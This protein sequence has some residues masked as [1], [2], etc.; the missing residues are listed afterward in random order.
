MAK[1][2]SSSLLRNKE[3]KIDRLLSFM[4]PG[5]GEGVFPSTRSAF[6]SLSL[7]PATCNKTER[8][9]SPPGAQEVGTQKNVQRE[10]WGWA[11]RAGRGV[12]ERHVYKKKRGAGGV[13]GPGSVQ[14]NGS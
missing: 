6:S 2:R 7:C 1:Y 13:D 11:S 12:I 10:M 5:A 4:F 9:N 8:G 3:Q 14:V